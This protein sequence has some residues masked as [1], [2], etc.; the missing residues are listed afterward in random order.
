MSR[1]IKKVKILIVDDDKNLCENIEKILIY[2]GYSV[3][4]AF[5]GPKALQIIRSE[6]I[7]IVLL[8]LIMPKMSGL[9]VF[10]KIRSIDKNMKIII[11]TGYPSVETAVTTLR[12]QAS[13]YITKPFKNINLLKVVRATAKKA[14]LIENPLDKLDYCIGKN[15]KSIRMKKSLLVKD[16]AERTGLSASLISQIE[17]GKNA[18]SM[19]TL[20]KIA[21]VLEVE[22]SD[23]THGI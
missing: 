4:T 6:K 18:A 10:Y 23:L 7:D 19:L 1:L 20:Y 17:N 5:D 16:L 12:E 3:K 13:D 15:V 8:D 9:D 11:L 2:E 14:G 21:R 22:L